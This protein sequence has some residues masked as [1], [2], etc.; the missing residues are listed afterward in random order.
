EPGILVDDA[1]VV[2]EQVGRTVQV[3]ANLRPDFHRSVRCDVDR[4]KLVGPAEFLVEVIDGVLGTS[5][6]KDSVPGL[7]K[8]I[9]HR[10]AQALR[11]AGDENYSAARHRLG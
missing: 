3:Q 11:D 2:D 6:A 10:L 5:T 7:D 8:L 9:Q 4:I 1:G